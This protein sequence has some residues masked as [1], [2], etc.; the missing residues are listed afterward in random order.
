MNKPPINT[1]EDLQKA[2]DDTPS[3][4]E[5]VVENTIHIKDLPVNLRGRIGL[6]LA[7]V[8]DGKLVVRYRNL[9]AIR[10]PVID[11]VGA[12]RL[13]LDAVRIQ[14]PMD[15]TWQ[16]MPACAG[17]FGRLSDPDHPHSSPGH[18]LRDCEIDGSYRCACVYNIGSELLRVVDT[19]LKNDIGSCYMTSS[20]NVKQITSPH[21]D[22][23]GD[24]EIGGS[25]KV[26]NVVQWFERI[27]FGAT[28]DNPAFVLYP[29]GGLVNLM[30][31][32]FS[33][34][35]T[36]PC[37]IYIGHQTGWGET[38]VP[39]WPGVMIGNYAEYGDNWRACDVA[40]SGTF[41]DFGGVRGRLTAEG[42]PDILELNPGFRRGVRFVDCSVKDFPHP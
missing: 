33:V 9:E 19:G 29:E 14:S 32:S 12:Y 31:N 20:W 39:C 11:T 10:W 3:Y 34:K 5:V 7:C 36:G 42:Y 21:G 30:N 23:A 6:R 25:G 27:H 22:M 2:I 37:S 28:G 38:P 24:G 15:A 17:L 4:G 8:G 35:G 18:R 40:I 41:K 13:L 1:A 16:I 26:S